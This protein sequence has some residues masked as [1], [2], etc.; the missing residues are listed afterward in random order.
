MNLQ[1]ISLIRVLRRQKIFFAAFASLALSGCPGGGG[2]DFAGLD[3]STSTEQN[4]PCK[5]SSSTPTNST[6]KVAASSGT[7]TLFTISP[8]TS[9]CKVYFFINSVQVNTASSN[10]IE[11][12]S[13]QLTSGSNTISVQA[14]NDLGSDTKSWTVTKNTP[15]TC[16]R[17]SPSASS[18]NLGVTAT[19]ALT[20]TG[21]AESGETLTFAWKLDG[22]TST[23]LVETISNATASQAMFSSA[24][25]TT[26]VHTA[27]ASVSDGYDTTTC[28]WSVNVDQDCALTAKS[29]NVTSLRMAAASGTTSNFSVTASTA[30]CLVSWTINS[31]SVSGTTTNRTVNTSELTTGANILTAT[32]TSPSGTST[33]TWTIIKN[34]PPTCTQSPAASGNSLSV[35]STLNLTS[36]ISDSNS[37]TVTWSWKQNSSATTNPPVVITDGSNTTTAAFTPQASHIGYNSFDLRLDDGYDTTTCTWAV[38]VMP[39]CQISSSSPSGVTSTIANLGTTVNAFTVVPNDA[40][41]TISWSL[42][43]ISLGTSSS[44]VNLLSSSF[45]TTNTLTATVSNGA[46]SQSKSWTVTKNTPP[47]C[48]SYSPAHTG[49]NLAVAATQAFTANITES[50]GGQTLSYAWKLDGATPSATYFSNTSTSNSATGTWTAL[51]GQV[52]SHT[53]A[54]DVTDG[55]DPVTCSWPVDVLRSCAVSTA[56]PSGSSLRVSNA[57]STQTSFLVVAN[58]PGCDVVWRLNGTTVA[59]SVPNY[60]VLSSALVAGTPDTLTATL[61]NAVSS[62]TRTWSVQRNSKPVCSSQTP[63]ATGN[64]VNVGGSQVFTG[65]ATDA[66]SDTLAFSWTF[67]GANSSLF[68]SISNSATASTATFTPGL[69]NVGT[70]K[71][72][73]LTMNDGYDSATCTWTTDV[74]DPNSAQILSWTPTASPVVILSN[75]SQ[76]FTVSAS[77]TGITYAW[78][79]DSVVQSGQTT[80]SSTYSYSDMSVGM[81]TLKAKVTDTYATTAEHSFSVKRNAAPAISAHTPNVTGVTTYKLNYSSTMNFDVTATD[82]NSDTLTYTWTLDNATSTKFSSSNTSST[83]LSPGG[84]SLLLG[85]HTVKVEINDGH[86]STFQTWTVMINLF[87]DDCNAL[88][89]SSPTGSNGGRTCTLIG[90]PSMGHN[91]DILTDPTLL[92]ARPTYIIELE[93]GVYAFSDIASHVVVVYNSNSGGGNKSYFGQTIAPG[94]AMVVI[95]NGAQGRN[96]DASSPVS[97]WQTVGTAPTQVTMPNFKL[98][99]P[100]DLAYDSVRGVL[101]IADRYNRRV[102]ALN[103]S[104]M[105][106]RVLGLTGGSNTQNSTTNPL[107]ETFG[108]D[109]VC[110]QPIGLTIAGRY[111]YVGCYN[112]DV[113]KRVN[114]DDPSNSSTYT[115]AKTVVGRQNA[116]SANILSPINSVSPDGLGGADNT[117]STGAVAYANTPIAL[118]SDNAGLVYWL[119]IQGGNQGSNLRVYN[120]TGSAVTFY[121]SSPNSDHVSL[122]GVF[123]FQAFDLTGSSYSS[124][125]FQA[126]IVNAVSGTLAQ[127]GAQTLTNLGQ[128]NCHMINVRLLDSGGTPIILGTSTTVTMSVISGTGAYYSDAACSSALPSNQFSIPAGVSQG[129]VFVKMTATGAY[130]LRATVSALTASATGTVVATTT[131]AN[132]IR[133]TAPPRFRPDEC[134]LTEFTLANSTTPAKIAAGRIV[135]PASNGYGSY[136]SDSSCTT[137][138]DRLTFTSTDATQFAYFKRNVVVPAGWVGSLVGYNN[139]AAGSYG[140]Y[141]NYVKIGQMRFETGTLRGLG[142]LKNGGTGLPD[143]FFYTQQSQHY[144]GMINMKTSSVTYGETVPSQS[145]T[146]VAGLFNG[147][148]DITGGYNGEDQAA[149]GT[150][151]NQPFGLS[152]NLAQDKVLF[153]DYINA[154]GRAFELDTNGYIRTNIGAGRTR[155]RYG[156]IV[157]DPTQVAMVNPYKLEVFNGSLYFSE[158]GNHRIRKTNLSSGVTDLIAG[159]GQTGTPT[160]G[161]DAIADNMNNPRGFKVIAYPNTT[162]PTNYVLFYAENCTVRAVNLSGPTISNFFGAGNLILGKVKTIAGDTSFGCATWSSNNSDGMVATTARLNTPEDIAYIDGEIYIV[163]ASDHCIVKVAT[164]GTISRPQGVS[165]CSTTVPSSND[166]TM[167]LMRTRYPKSF[168]PDTAKPGNYFLIDQYSDNTGF[169]RYLNTLTSSITFKNSAPITVSARANSTAPIPVKTVY[170]YSATS[171]AS[172]VGGVATWVQ[173]SGSAGSNDKICWTAGVL[174]DGS[175]GAHAVYCA[176]RNQDDDGVLAAGSSNGS[177]MRGGGPLDREQEKISRLNATFY[178]PYGIAFDDDGNLYISEFNNHV[179]R[180]IRKWW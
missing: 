69:G 25:T 13:S 10:Y 49:T 157:N 96:N 160:E 41:C 20:A 33:Q 108:Y 165:S 60:D 134:V 173:T 22:S 164:N 9:S 105:A 132:T 136:Y 117:P 133:V 119:E 144:V 29:P 147:S 78:E 102:I 87:S 178:A 52:G 58:D 120:P 21:T 115:L 80:A 113:I 73:A 94:K 47:V 30:S 38:Q 55:Y 79:L 159:N 109:Q 63:A 3:S 122:P 150:K 45:G 145:A 176:N 95:G 88:Y 81:H 82:A 35:G 149:F 131:T 110:D 166:A 123:N 156:V 26:G 137:R 127:L 59:S 125:N 70:S 42:N 148:N 169:I 28:D 91:Q 139:S 152:V 138:I 89:N 142:V 76:T 75:G 129:S 141:S 56:S 27:T 54:V 93:A 155:D 126:N 1:K 5:I 15:P 101:Y 51:S 44:I 162:S 62:T 175:N 65:N 16:T 50:D 83:T 172:G 71:T 67:D 121:S 124:T 17:T 163:N 180:M 103:S 43:S 135:A 90:N 68:S 146:V 74:V 72:V 174:N 118:A 18:F 153:G 37:D 111:L 40:S 100:S 99:E 161:N 112:Q 36:N 140:E 12:D 97:V 39:Q 64:S 104:G 171:G 57:P 11:V 92:K 130:N 128:N 14:S 48:A 177:G 114:I 158:Y 116:S 151:L 168:A 77:G 53:L 4:V 179:I 84:D 66:E 2:S 85:Q 61:T 86:E 143:A 8:S 19:Q 46:S 170:Q 23:A 32:V 6:T 154:R 106:Y 7:K 31:A 24:S 167:D 98:N 34:S 107:T